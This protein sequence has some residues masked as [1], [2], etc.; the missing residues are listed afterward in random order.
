MSSLFFIGGDHTDPMP[1]PGKNERQGRSANI[2][3]FEG[4]V[5]G[6]GFFVAAIVDRASK[7]CSLTSQHD[8]R[9]NFRRATRR[10]IAGCERDERYQQ[11]HASESQRVGRAYPEE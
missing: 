6:H 3:F 8:Q 4:S 1:A 5:R 2:F 7:R 11:P 9:I 10:Q